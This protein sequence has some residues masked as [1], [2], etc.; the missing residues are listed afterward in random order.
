MFKGGFNARNNSDSQNKFPKHFVPEFKFLF[1][2]KII[3]CFFLSLSDFL[4][5]FWVLFCLMAFALIFPPEN[6]FNQLTDV[7]DILGWATRHVRI[8][9]KFKEKFQFLLIFENVL[10]LSEFVQQ[11]VVPLLVWR[12]EGGQ[13]W[14]FRVKFISW[15][16][17]LWECRRRRFL[18]RRSSLTLLLCEML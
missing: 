2:L 3:L 16:G 9:G 11:K 7:R 6:I 15:K 10:S 12:Y 5:S 4:N 8:A 17:L 18:V 1:Y 13:I 14:W